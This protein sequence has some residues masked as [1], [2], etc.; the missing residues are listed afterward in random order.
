MELTV[1]GCLPCPFGLSAIRARAELAREQ[2][3][4]E[5]RELF[6]V[7][8]AWALSYPGIPSD[9][10]RAWCELGE[11]AAHWARIAAEVP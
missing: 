3:R 2:G 9:E 10:A 5:R 6:A 7:D 11:L 1:G 8:A 4:A